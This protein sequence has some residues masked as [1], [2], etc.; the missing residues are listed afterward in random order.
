MSDVLD[1]IRAWHTKYAAEGSGPNA[2]AIAEPYTVDR[3]YDV[4][5]LLTEIDR[6]TGRLPESIFMT[7]DDIAEDLWQTALKV[8]DH[9]RIAGWTAQ[10]L[11]AW[12]FEEWETIIPRVPTVR[13]PETDLRTSAITALVI[14]MRAAS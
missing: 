10:Q 11:A 14:A 13:T 2:A 9:E 4:D 12:E 6:L 1:R 8:H 7:A 5:A 3:W